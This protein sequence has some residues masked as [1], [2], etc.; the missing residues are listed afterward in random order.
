MKQRIF[1]MQTTIKEVTVTIDIDEYL[2]IM[3]KLETIRNGI[4][5]ES[6]AKHAKDIMNIIEEIKPVY[7]WD[8]I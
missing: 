7:I 4:S 8:E 1:D 6:A 2:D 3:A 5:S